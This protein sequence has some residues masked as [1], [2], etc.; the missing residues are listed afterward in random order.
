MLNFHSD[1]F[2]SISPKN[3]MRSAM[4][5]QIVCGNVA[6]LVESFVVHLI[7]RAL[8]AIGCATAFGA[9]SVICETIFI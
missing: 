5:L 2:C 9:G 1:E 3:V 6:G 7:F 8:A 4:I